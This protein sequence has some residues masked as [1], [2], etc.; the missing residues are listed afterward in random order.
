METAI[1]LFVIF[2][3]ILGVFGSVFTV[4]AVIARGRSLSDEERALED[5][6][7]M[8]YLSNR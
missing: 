7:Q 6:E 3:V 4:A 8:E 5:Q 2:L 1:S